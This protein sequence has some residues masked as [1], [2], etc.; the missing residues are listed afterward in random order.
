MP[1]QRLSHGRQ[2]FGELNQALKLSFFLLTNMIIVI[3]V[4]PAPGG[5]LADGLHGAS[6]G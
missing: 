3:D 1:G 5:V 2:A 6:G 4:L